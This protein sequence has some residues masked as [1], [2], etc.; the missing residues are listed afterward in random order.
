[1]SARAAALR[2]LARRRLTE[3]QLWE[4]LRRRGYD[5]DDVRE[6]V[7][8]CKADHFLDDRLY[9][10]LYVTGAR[11]P[12]GD[13]RLAGDLVLRG[14]DRDVAAVAV[15]SCQNDEVTRCSLALT[16]LLRRK[17]EM[18]YPS[19][20]RALERSGFPAHLIYRVLREHAARFGPL[21]ALAEVELS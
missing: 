7:A 6:A 18:S 8:S 4:R 3:A 14:I 21:A 12:V 15:A 9:A 16:T 20:A 13:A 1:M 17:P 2:L 10:E 5:E 19:A 11:K